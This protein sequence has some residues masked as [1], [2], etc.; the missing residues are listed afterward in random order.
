MNP[1]NLTTAAASVNRLPN[2]PMVLLSPNRGCWHCQRSL[3]VEPV[4]VIATDPEDVNSCDQI[5]LVCSGHC[6]QQ[7]GDELVLAGAKTEIVG[8]RITLSL[9][10]RL[11]IIA[12]CEGRIDGE[13]RQYTIFTGR[14]AVRHMKSLTSVVIQ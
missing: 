4:V 3:P 12:V 9:L 7:V 2:N 11:E 6:A 5:Y 8:G 13:I 14:L 1:K 10:R